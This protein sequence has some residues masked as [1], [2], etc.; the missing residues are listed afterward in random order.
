M[1]RMAYC[2]TVSDSTRCENTIRVY[3]EATRYVRRTRNARVAVGNT[4]C[5]TDARSC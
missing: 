4:T 3:R 2:S 5:D 1:S